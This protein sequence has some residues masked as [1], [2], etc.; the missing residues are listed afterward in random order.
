MMNYL[1]GVEPEQSQRR[2]IVDSW[3]DEG[4]VVFGKG[5]VSSIFLRGPAVNLSPKLFFRHIERA[6]DEI[7]FAS[8]LC[9]YTLRNYD[10]DKT[11]RKLEKNFAKQTGY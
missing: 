3:E 9:E 10:M 1:T 6:S 8:T 5:P 11:A 4:I 7:H 2:K